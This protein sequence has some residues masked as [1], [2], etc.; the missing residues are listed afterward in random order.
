MNV[1]F[2]LILLLVLAAF[3]VI[4]MYVS[5]PVVLA[6][7]VVFGAW[8][9]LTRRGRQAASVTA[10]G[11]STLRQ[12]LGSSSVVIVG[13]AGVVGVLVALLAMGDGYAQTL[14]KTGSDD[15]AIVMRGGSAS[16]VMSVM[17]H[18]SVVV[19]PQAPGIARDSQGKPIASPE[20]VV[21]A[22]LPVKG[23]APDEEGSVQLRGV[24]EQA[25]AVRPHLK[26]I[27]GRK[28]TPGMRELD[29]G[30]GAQRQFAG[31]QPGHQ[32]KLGN[33]EWTVVGVFASNDA[34]DSEIWGDADTVASTYRRGSSRASVTVKLTGPGAYAAFK[35]ALA[36]DPRLKVD[37][38]TTL[39]YFGKQ[40]EGMS[41]VMRIMGITVG[42]IM[43]I[44][45]V[46]GALNTMFAAV[47]S[48]AREIATLRAIGFRGPPVVI[49]IML[50]TMLL[51]LLGGLLGGLVAWLVFN[52]YTASTM[53]AGTVGQLTFAFK[54]SPELLWQGLKWALAIGFVGGLFPAVRAARLPVTTALREL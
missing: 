48:R 34:L 47:A 29:V 17:E 22:N 46:F 45:A 38:D 51:A 13:I 15:T 14:R 4:W 27:A 10:V 28:F 44:G 33:Q 12:R 26:I 21:A 25:W 53:A 41:K 35:A 39:D 40:S 42:L 6:L 7:A 1:I 20:I 11:L 50:E 32:V 37:T 31:L 16:E 30:Q 24:G 5:W 9:L 49:A 3:L 43:A 54:V 36:A 8:M 18:D 23:G 52:G 19:V 2:N